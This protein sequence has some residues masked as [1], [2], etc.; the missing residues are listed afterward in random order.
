MQDL[1]EQIL[2]IV[3]ESAVVAPA[4]LPPLPWDTRQPFRGRYVVVPKTVTQLSRVLAVCHEAGQAV[5]PLGGITGL[6]QGCATRAGDVGLS[7]RALDRIEEVDPVAQTM[8]AGAGVTLGDAQR[9]AADAG[10]YFP[11]DIGARDTCMLGGNA[12][13]NA[14]GTRVIRYG[15]MRDSVLGLEAV[16]ADGT[17][18]SSMNRYLKNNS[19]FDLK[20]LF[21]G[22]E[23]T[24]GV[25]TRLVIRLDV[26]P[27]SHDVALL[28]A[29]D[30]DD[31]VGM[32]SRLRREL[33]GR[34]CGF[35][36]MWESFFRRAV[37]P[38]GPRRSPFDDEHPFYVIVEATGQSP[39][40]DGEVFSAALTG[41]ME[42]GL[43]VDGVVAKSERDCEDIWGIRHEVEWLV[44]DAYNFDVSLRV[45]DVGTYI[46]DL[47]QRIHA[48]FPDAYVAAFGHLGDNNVHISVLGGEEVDVQRQVYEALAPFDGAVSAEHGIGLEK[49]PYL[50]LT[51]SE[52]EIALM[53]TLKAALD[54]RGILNPGKVF[55]SQRDSANVS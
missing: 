47:E 21:I 4:D 45:A 8:T 54:P 28:A 17:V 12:S 2:N 25:I 49:R 32:L 43:A 14:G 24:L 46:D 18:I 48:L 23:G 40:S 33:G 19:G 35:E 16:L 38:L 29:T 50:K 9:A 15:M 20:Q 34:L 22:T 55:E 51:R 3:G 26:A 53:R 41:V 39:E 37:E 44:R 31:V 5:V 11:V 1:D 6:V 10:L 27:R 52:D 42:D 30:F 36:V 7:V 13:T